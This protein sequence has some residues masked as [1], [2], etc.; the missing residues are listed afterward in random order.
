MAI[1]EYK[2]KLPTGAKNDAEHTD[3]EGSGSGGQSGQIA[4]KSFLPTETLRDDLLP[5]QKKGLLS[6]HKDISAVNILFQKTRQEFYKSLKNNTFTS[7]G[8][9]Y[10]QGQGGSTN[11]SGYPPHPVLRHSNQH[12]GSS[13]QQ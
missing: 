11:Q 6:H 10:G 12:N 7:S 3:E 4:F 5:E 1:D 13:D 9:N 2:K 8:M